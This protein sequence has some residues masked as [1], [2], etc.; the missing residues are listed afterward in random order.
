MLSAIWIV[1]LAVTGTVTATSSRWHGD[2]IVTEAE[3]RDA[4]GTTLRVVQ[5]GG[6]VDGL[7]MTFSHQPVLVREGDRVT[8]D[9]ATRSVVDVAPRAALLPVE[10]TA[11]YGVQRTAKSGTPLWRDTGCLELTYDSIT[12][13]VDAARAIDAA[14]AAWSTATA[15]C[16]H[17][18]A[19]STRR[20][21]PASRR[22]GIS[23]VRIRVDRWCN[24]GDPLDPPVCYAKEA[25][26]VTR[27]LFVDDPGDP[28]DGKIIEA[29]IE[30]NAVDYVLVAP[31]D[32][33]PAAANRPAIDLL[34]VATHEAGHAL[35]L[36][37]NCGT[38]REPWPSDHAGTPVPACATAAPEV[39]AATMYF[40]VAPGDV[41]AR[42]VEASDAAGAC[43]L[44]RELTCE[45]YVE[46]GCHTAR[47]DASLWLTVL[48]LVGIGAG[49]R[50]TR[51]RAAP[52]ALQQTTNSSKPARGELDQPAVD[53]TN[54]IFTGAVSKSLTHSGGAHVHGDVFDHV[55]VDDL[56]RTRA[57]AASSSSADRG[58]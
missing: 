8:I 43:E 18:V 44:A 57:S 5:L 38:G 46:G 17:V 40:A 48:G 1:G 27:L 52:G 6:S 32:A 54:M 11:T 41:G 15:S 23:T 29:D 28:D 26:A 19:T 51:R 34:A 24:P 56:G 16:G 42:S 2:V 49:L 10:G 36:A 22:D 31:G 45:S 35:G 33:A 30:L 58:A 37:H 7:G 50:R 14:F 20:A 3:V 25:S 4:T 12:I 39:R 21:N 47:D 13:S 9:P 53:G 55:N